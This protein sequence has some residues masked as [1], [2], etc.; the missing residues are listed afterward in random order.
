MSKDTSLLTGSRCTDANFTF[1]ITMET[2]H[3]VPFTIGRLVN[4]FY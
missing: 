4:P 2:Q 3:K 1:E